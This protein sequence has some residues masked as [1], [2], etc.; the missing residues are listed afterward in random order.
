MSGLAK[1]LSFFDIFLFSIGYI[2]GAGI[3]ILIGKVA[4]HSKGLS[5]VSFMIS[6]ILAL[7]IAC[8]YGDLS[9]LYQSNTSEFD[10][11]SELFGTI[12]AIITSLLLL[13]IGIFTTTTV[14]LSISDSLSTFLPIS[15][16]LIAMV[17]IVFFWFCQLSRYKN[18]CIL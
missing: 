9:Y 15:P 12:P 7:L 5:W 3:F 2:I 1:E 6:G 16:I 10:Y 13:L 18:D 11:V 14:S 17:I 4:K 8:S